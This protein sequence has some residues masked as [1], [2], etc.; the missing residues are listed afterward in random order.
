MTN[1]KQQKNDAFSHKISTLQLREI[2]CIDGPPQEEI[3]NTI[4]DEP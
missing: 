1:E 2:A 4:S 3:V